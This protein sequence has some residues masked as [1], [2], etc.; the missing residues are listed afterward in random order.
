[1][2]K[3]L[4]KSYFLIG[5]LLFLLLIPWTEG[6]YTILC[7]VNISGFLLYFLAINY[8]P[9]A[10]PY[11]VRHLT[12]VVLLYSIFFVSVFN[13]I[14]YYYEG[15]FFMFSE[16]DALVYHDF[17]RDMV[18]RSWSDAIDYFLRF[19]TIDDLGMVLVLS[20]VYSVME[21]N[22]LFNA[23]NI[24][25]G[26]FTTIGIFRIGLHLMSRKYAFICALSFSL[27]S[28]V[29]WFH[30]SGLKE[31]FMIMLVVW[32]FDQY[33]AY[34]E[35]RRS[36]NIIVALLL[37]ASLILFRPPLMFFC[38]GAI[39]LGT[40]AQRSMSLRKLFA[41]TVV[42]I[43]VGASFS[44][45]ESSFER[46]LMGGNI[47]RLIAAREAQ[48]MVKGSLPFTY[49]VNA[50]AQLIGPLPSVISEFSPKLSLYSPGLIF[51][52]LL[53]FPFLIGLYYLFRKRVSTLY[54]LALFTLME[55]TSLFMIL[56]GLELRKSLPHLPMVYII[57]FWFMDIYNTKLISK[58][59][60]IQKLFISF[61]FVVSTIIIYWNF[62]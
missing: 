57:G 34:I 40:L 62:R 36:S 1:M 17:A 44:Y 7:L 22:L 49:S 54:P 39:G 16:A 59:S 13:I 3:K 50:L 46:Y 35:N 21:S 45:L 38:F 26:V 53:S 42:V 55:M 31:S 14:S 15:N 25:I 5:G 9:K 47:D 6:N 52:V 61:C 27:S 24:L 37:A 19:Y 2:L 30:A 58:K 60:K 4:N 43:A 32:F 29:L 18:T 48:G 20:A 10:K 23:F 56:E 11:Q 33:Y 12:V 28:Y 51:R 41:I 8:A